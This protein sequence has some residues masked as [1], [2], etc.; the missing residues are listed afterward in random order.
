MRMQHDY[1]FIASMQKMQV[2]ETLDS[3]LNVIAHN[4]NY[5]NEAIKG[6]WK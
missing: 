3:L 2:S 1:Y 5:V 6:F 4:F